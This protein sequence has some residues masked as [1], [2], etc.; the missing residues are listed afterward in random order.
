MLYTIHFAFIL[1]SYQHADSK[2]S[3]EVKKEKQEEMKQL[4]LYVCVC[5][6]REAKNE[7]TYSDIALK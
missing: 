5:V 3:C 6:C 7:A 2:E 1:I 4:K